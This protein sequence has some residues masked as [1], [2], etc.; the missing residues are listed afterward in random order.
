MS[1]IMGSW[2]LVTEFLEEDGD[3]SV[4]I[5]RS[6]GVPLHLALGILRTAVLRLESKVMLAS[7]EDE[8]SD[9]ENEEIADE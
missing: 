4:R 6:E 9:D 8:W 3:M 7:F 5:A 2:V 1:E